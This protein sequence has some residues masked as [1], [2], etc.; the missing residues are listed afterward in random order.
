[1]PKTFSARDRRDIKHL[2]KGNPYYEHKKYPEPV[3]CSVCGLVFLGGRWTIKTVREP[4]KNNETCPACRL[5]RD[6]LPLGVAEFEGKFLSE[7]AKKELK[8]II[9]NIEERV[10]EKRPLQRIMKTED[11]GKKITVWTTYDHLARRIGEAVYKAFKGELNIKYAEGE[12]FARIY[13]RRD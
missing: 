13:W 9:K 12:R 1:M 10:R 5:I 4:I 8:N 2:D 7:A 11:D 3:E 6:K